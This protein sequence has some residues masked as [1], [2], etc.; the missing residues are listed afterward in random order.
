MPKLF[1]SS[2]EPMK[3]VDLLIVGLA[4]VGMEHAAAETPQCPT[5]LDGK[6]IRV[7]PAQTGWQG[8][9][10]KKVVLESAGIVIGPP[11]VFA[12]AELRGSEKRINRNTSQTKF[13][14]LQDQDQKW[15]ICSYGQGGNLEQ[16]YRLPDRMNQ[17]VI[18]RT[19]YAPANRIEIRVACE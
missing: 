17:C 11:D 16:A 19:H 9:A 10:A 7:Q 2:G 4:V 15:L 3:I 18:T 1:T 8:L 13:S 5:E 12:R 6:L 14:G